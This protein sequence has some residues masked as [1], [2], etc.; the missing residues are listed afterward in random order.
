MFIYI[1]IKRFT[2][3][4]NNTSKQVLGTAKLNQKYE[5]M[6]LKLKYNTYLL[7]FNKVLY[8]CNFFKTLS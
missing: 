4:R 6:E 5:K 8:C 2:L 1:Y 7:K 3:N